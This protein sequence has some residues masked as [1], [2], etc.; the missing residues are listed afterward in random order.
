M[1]AE[2]IISAEEAEVI[3]EPYVERLALCVQAGWEAWEELGRVAPRS[4]I[5]LRPHTRASFVYDHIV[6]KAR[7]DFAEDHPRV[8]VTE[9]NQLLTLTF[10][11]RLI[12]RF[13]KFKDDG[14][15]RTSGIPTMQQQL[16]AYQLPLPGMPH[17]ATKLVTGY[18]L[19]EL[20]AS[21]DTV[22]I[23]CS[24]GPRLEWFLDITDAGGE[25]DSVVEPIQPLQPGGPR[26]KPKPSAEPGLDEASESR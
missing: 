5:P 1:E 10:E 9:K 18:V 22:A 14:N 8:R 20:Q 17:E 7:D 3:L 16:F 26:I 4:R 15:F 19:D 13:K 11:D 23:A 2:R 24:D 25:S 6:Q 12:V 21:I